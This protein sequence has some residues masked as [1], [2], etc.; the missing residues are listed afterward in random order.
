MPTAGV[1]SGYG[2]IAVGT[3]SQ[4]PV[5]WKSRDSEPS[6][7]SCKLIPARPKCTGYFYVVLTQLLSSK[8]KETH[9]KKMPPE[10]LA[11]GNTVRHIFKLVIDG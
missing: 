8:R 4:A 11:P 7:Q 9:L 3:G 10:D 1:T 5:L 6:L 2:P